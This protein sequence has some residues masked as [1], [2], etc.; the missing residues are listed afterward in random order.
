MKIEFGFYLLSLFSC[1]IGFILGIRSLF[2]LR[3]KR[4]N[5][6]FVKIILII[7][8]LI[9]IDIINISLIYFDLYTSLIIDLRF[10][11]LDL[12]ILL[13]LIMNNLYQNYLY[14]NKKK[15]TMYIIYFITGVALITTFIMKTE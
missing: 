9:S 15:I 13:L 11:L 8:I 14:N 3:N 5:F 6:I 1:V 10:R 7:E 12:Y 2:L 4:R